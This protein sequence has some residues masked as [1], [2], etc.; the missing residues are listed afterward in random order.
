MVWLGPSWRAMALSQSVPT[1]NTQ[2]LSRVL[3]RDPVGAPEAA[4]NVAVAPTA[5]EPLLPP[6]SAPLNATTV[7]EAA[8]LC[9]KFAVTATLLKI[10]GANARQISAS[11]RTPF[12]RATNCHVNPAPFTDITVFPLAGLE[13]VE[14]NASN[15]SFALAVERD[16]VFTEF[17]AEE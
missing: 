1:P 4:L 15:N 14:M 6:G 11:P 13:S 12:A 7:M 2:E 16:C 3:T 9:P 10:V 5:P 17:V 8:A